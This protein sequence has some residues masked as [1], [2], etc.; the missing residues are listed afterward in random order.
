MGGGSSGTKNEVGV[1]WVN[2]WDGGAWYVI[3]CFTVVDDVIFSASVAEVKV[4]NREHGE[5]FGLSTGAGG[6]SISKRLVSECHEARG[7]PHCPP[8]SPYSSDVFFF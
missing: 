5:R 2:L 4:L 7:I 8:D 3:N 1:I 6:I